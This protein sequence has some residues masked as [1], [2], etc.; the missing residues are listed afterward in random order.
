MIRSISSIMGV[1]S[2]GVSLTAAGQSNQPKLNSSADSKWQLPVLAVQPQKAAPSARVSFTSAPLSF[3]PNRGQAAPSAKFVSRGMGY[4]LLLEQNGARFQFNSKDQASR[5]LK[6]EFAGASAKAA[7]TGEAQLPGKADYFPTGNPKTWITDV[8][9]YSRVRYADMYPG[10]DVAFYGSAHRLEYDV[11]VQPG[12][13]PG[14]VRMKLSGSDHASITSDGELLVGLGK[15]NLR[16]LKPVVYQMS[17]D[18]KTRE[19]VAAAY[20]IDRQAGDPAVSFTLGAYD[21][22]RQLVIDPVVAL[23]YSEFLS[24]YAGSV[25]V[26][27]AGNT[28]VTGTNFSN[29]FYI[30]KFN[31][32]GTVVYNATLGTGYYTYP[33][34]IAIGASGEAY[35]TGDVNIADGTAPLS[36]NA[37]ESTVSSEPAGFLTVLSASGSSVVYGT[38]LSGTDTAPTNIQG[39]AVDSSGDAYLTGQTSSATF[40]VTT[41]AYQTTFSSG[42]TGFVAKLN[43]AA[44]T[45]ATSLVYSTYLGTSNTDLYSV[46]VDSAG[47]AYVTGYGSLGYPLTSG[48]FQYD[49]IYVNSG[50]AVVTKL[51]PT[52]TALIYSAYLGYGYGLGIAVDNQSSP[53]A[54]IT[55]VV[56]GADFPTTPGAYQTNYG[57]GFVTKLNSAGSAETFSTF[58]SGPSGYTVNG[59]VNPNSI[60]LLNG[61]T[62]SCNVY[63][64]GWT[65]TADYPQ[66]DPI[67]STPSTT[68]DNAFVTEIS[69]TGASALFSSY[70]NGINSGFQSPAANNQHGNTPAI[71]VDSSGNISFVANFYDTSDFPITVAT[72]N[73][74]TAILARIVPQST[75]ETF[76]EPPSINFGSQPVGVSTSVDN[77]T[78]TVRIFNESSTAAILQPIVV[79]P[80]SVFAESDSCNGTI[81]GGGY[82]TLDIDFTPNSASTRSG[83]IT[84]ASNAA[85]SPTVVPVSG[86]GYDEAYVQ[87]S[88][89]SLAFPVTVVGSG[90]AAQ[91]VTLTNLGDATASLN[92]TVGT[93]DFQQLNNC[94]SQLLPGASCTVSVTFMPTQAGLR[95]DTLE[96]QAS[97]GPTTY[98]GLQGTGSASGSTAALTFS[99]PTIQFGPEVVGTTSGAQAFEVTNSGTSPAVITAI[100]PGSDYALTYIGCGGLPLVIQPGTQCQ[101][102]VVFAPTAA[103]TRTGALTFTD[104]ATGNPQAV[105]LTGTGVASTQTVQFYP[106]TAVAFPDTPVGTT[107][108]AQTIYLQNV[109]SSTLTVDRST[110]SGPFQLSYGGCEARTVGGYIPDGVDGAGYCQVNVVFVPTATGTQ[111]G[112]LTF[113]DSAPGSP[114]VV[115]LS[116]NAI[117]A[118]GTLVNQPSGLNFGTQAVGTT[119]AAQYFYY[120]NPGNTPV[121]VNS[122]TFTGTNASDFS[123]GTGSCTLPDTVQP[124]GSCYVYVQFTPSAA[125]ARTA[126]MNINSSAGDA[127]TSLAGTGATAALAVG[128]TPTSMNQ[129]TIVVG[130]SSSSDV[131]YLRNSG[132]EPI[133]FSAAPAITGTNASDFAASNGCVY[134]GDT[135][136]VG[137]TCNLNVTFTPGAAGARSATLSITDN[138][139]TQ[140]LALSGTGEAAKPTYTLSDYLSTYNTQVEGT[141]SN[142]NLVYFYN[143]GSSP[144]T[145]GNITLTSSFIIPSGDNTCNGAA[146]NAGGY[147]YVYVEFAPATTGYITG[148]LTWNSSGGTALAGAPVLQLAGFSATPTYAAYMNPNA[149]GFSTQQV[150][151]TTSNYQT[152][153]LYNSGNTPFT[154]G[155]VTGTDFGTPSSTAEFSVSPS[156]SGFDGCSGNSVAAGSTCQVNVTFTPNTAGARTGTIQFPIT[157]S[158]STTAT[159]TGNLTGSGVTEKDSAELTPPNG[160]FINQAVGVKTTYSVNTVLNNTGNRPFKV[161]AITNSNLTEFATTGSGTYDSC[162][163]N[164]VAIGS[165][166][167]VN[168]V[169]TPSAVGTRSGT[170]GFPVT[171]AD[172]STATINFPVTGTGVA[173]S[174]TVAISPS[175][176][177]FQTELQSVTSAAQGLTLTYTGNESAIISADSISTNSAEF[178]I[179]YDNCTGRT[180]TANQ[181]CSINV[182]FKPSS[183]AT[184]LQTGVLTISDNATGGPHTVALSGTA[185]TPSQQIVVSQTAL[186]FGNQPVNSTSSAQ[187]IYITN[188]S[189]SAVTNSGINITGTNGIDFKLVST[190]CGGTYNPHASCNVL[191]EFTPQAGSSGALTATLSEADS[192]TPGS[193]TVSLTG[194]SVAAGPAASL[195]PTALTYTT[196]N[197][198][199]TSAAQNFSVTNTGSANLVVSTVASTNATEFP[200]STDGCSGSTL[201]PNQHCIVSV[202]FA[203]TLGGSRTGT[204]T[205]ADN[206]TGSPQTVAL[207]GTGYGIPSPT[208]TPASLTFASTNIGSTAA[209]QTVTLK[210]S[211]TDTLAIS[212][213]AVTGVNAGDFSQTNTCSTTLAPAASC[214]VTVSFKPTAS[215]SRG[216]AVTFTDN[217]NN[218]AGA[219]QSAA[220]TGTGVAVPT[221]AAAPTSLTFP[222][223]SIGVASSV[224]SST[225]S[226]SGTGPLTITSIAIGGTNAGDYSETNTCGSTLNQAT[227]CTISVTFKPTASGTRAATVTVTDN[228]NGTAGSTQT[229]TLSGTGAGV[230]TAGL[231]PTVVAFTDTN[232]GVTATAQTVT[233][234]NTGTGAL[235]VAS[236]A[237]TGADPGDFAETNTCGASVATGASCSISVTFKPTTAGNRAATLTV[238]DN[239]GNVTGS[240][241]TASLS[242]TGIGI[243]TATATPSSLTFAATNVGVTTASQAVTLKNTGTG[244]L[245]ISTIAIGG[246]NAGDFADTTTCGS[247]LAVSATCTISVTFDPTAVGSRT[248]NLHIIDNSGNAGATQTV[249]LTG[250]GQTP[251]SASVSPTSLTF[252]SQNGGTTS[253]A[254]TVT[255]SNSGTVALSIASVAFTGT[256][257]GDFAQTNNCGSSLAGGGSCAISV[258]FSPKAGGTRT[259]SL[260]V[261]DNSGNVSGSTQ[262]VSLSGTGVAAPAV[263]FSPTSLS[264]PSTQAGSTAT[265]ALK[266]TNS[267][268]ATLNVTAISQTGTNASL[269]SHTSNC[270]G[271][272]LAPGS[273]CTVQVAFAPTAAGS[274]SASL[275]VTDN[276]TGSPQSI[277]M[278]GTATSGPAVTLS[279]TSLTFPSTQVGSTS[280]LPVTVTNSGGANLTVSLISNTGTN[281][282]L[283]THTSNCGNGATI[284]PGANCTINVIFT[285]TAAGTFSA[286]LNIT[287]NAPG[288]PQTVA[289]SATATAG[290]VATVSPTSLSFPSTA[291]GSTST[292]SFTIT[293]SGSGSLSVSAISNT[294][295]NPSNFTHTS[296]CGGNPLAAGKS[297]TVQV[298]FAPTAA[299][300]FSA[301]MNITDNATG[302]PQSV[303][304]SGT[305]S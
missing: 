256:N 299:G 10:V 288:S 141:S 298:T 72:S 204:I 148:T 197:V 263:T 282:S 57:G 284:A 147:C 264:F 157:Y 56:E 77:G 22:T 208:I 40:P 46:A 257:S 259:A 13:D 301:T 251:P 167:Q 81:A 138:A 229:I 189:D 163:N 201:T 215:G 232:V 43:P 258:T 64:G 217:A 75:A 236:V 26:D 127:T 19:T 130:Q 173:D 247:T 269:F 211:G 18:G 170:I 252:A 186:A 253:A 271:N 2:L 118:T 210:N 62:S 21:H 286:T 154:V 98:I 160:S 266:I 183:T 65:S 233:L 207:T 68:G 276:V 91:T 101:I 248:A 297:C 172:G 216:A 279:P 51:N 225:L 111:T 63:V 302:S 35:V 7:T 155:Q 123:V 260:V 80:S 99:S 128:L 240:T 24:D 33:F 246:A 135:L 9:T 159:V 95:T 142:S 109:G 61:C 50:G 20:A 169:F 14:R 149:L 59:N 255:L 181:S 156:Y 161:G 97:S 262:S 209:T 47:D 226:N 268:T 66:I 144:V 214:V 202:K 17:R 250:T 222:S 305:G 254:Q 176:I 294:G 219:T 227:S 185:I 242:G 244:T 178:A 188:Q 234:S 146:V 45:S 180:L 179:S 304:L 84:I 136:A 82:C 6:M 278:T 175:S 152:A 245:T 190:N 187:A 267:G 273:Y 110:V 235:T 213:I 241:Q 238:T 171:Y 199:S 92:I 193:H 249:T 8:P 228:A 93:T 89:T 116:G 289:L 283:F 71:A 69:S 303:T 88:V 49:G 153:Y 200:I 296:N 131:I 134:S 218:V 39:V 86:T 76:A 239:T 231:S 287:D 12:A 114:H 34:A 15:N 105:G 55:G 194:T 83:T 285:P 293:N 192:A 274:F 265:L 158:N 237:I 221:A 37:Y 203:P 177:Q 184:G 60:S 32:A 31:T 96:V 196:Q 42:T 275:S 206:A 212:S 29:G 145:L 52:G 280:T 102:N 23:N 36:S 272:P 38:Y 103:G 27:S 151:G 104:N 16:F 129:G 168:I 150:I 224:M 115:T 79:S 5:V 220:L 108:G 290:P 182:T 3:E 44:S 30:A 295:T 191:V 300:A 90:S 261:T 112:T 230:P 270:G 165:T 119:T 117:A 74:G 41:G 4:K 94:A 78:M 143:N 166:C 53:S 73:P 292:L 139:G 113:V 174:N 121:T 28:Y 205:V 106:S 164:N 107:S 198:G 126:T 25:A 1:I 67:Q 70:V 137:A 120:Q 48:S 281:A 125:G 54:Y 277:A 132:T 100:T 58:L 122:Y 87:T 162:S 291:S 195:S 243:P 124:N 140:T 133:T 85:N 11:L 223:T